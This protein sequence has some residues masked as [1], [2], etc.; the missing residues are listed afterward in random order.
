MTGGNF[1]QLVSSPSPVISVRMFPGHQPRLATAG[2]ACHVAVHVGD[3]A[4]REDRAAHRR[5]AGTYRPGCSRARPGG[6]R[7]ARRGNRCSG[8]HRTPGTRC[9]PQGPLRPPSADLDQATCPPGGGLG[10]VAGAI[11]T[12]RL[13]DP[14]GL[15]GPGLRALIADVFGLKGVAIAMSAIVTRVPGKDALISPARARIR[16]P[17]QHPGQRPLRAR[18]G[19]VGGHVLR[20]RTRA[21]SSCPVLPGNGYAEPRVAGFQVVGLEDFARGQPDPAPVHRDGAAADEPAGAQQVP[22]GKEDPLQPSRVDERAQRGDVMEK[23]L[24]RVNE[25]LDH[26]QQ[27]NPAPWPR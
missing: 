4:E 25:I 16:R 26:L 15:S 6:R 9:R 21:T 17:G 2:D 18:Q 3:V 24:G 19:A 10:R 13:T 22:V 1:T 12:A 14:V 5:P 20:A 8:G 11:P 23:R 27:P 7:A